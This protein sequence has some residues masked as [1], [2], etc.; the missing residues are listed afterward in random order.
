VH[1]S[2]NSVDNP[3]MTSLPPALVPLAALV[4]KSGVSLGGLGESDRDLLLALAARRLPTGQAPTEA[5]ATAGLRAGLAD[6]LQC[7]ATDAVELRRWLVD[8][9]FWSRDGFRREYRRVSPPDLLPARQSAAEAVSLIA[10]PAAWVHDLR[11]EIEARRRE[12]QERWQASQ[13]AQASK[14]PPA[15]P[16]PPCAQSSTGRATPTSLPGTPR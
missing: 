7:L 15:S 2:W 10:D 14:A 1:R 11:A 9:G 4:G 13:G 8:A 3:G 16:I 6:E 5:A 12:R